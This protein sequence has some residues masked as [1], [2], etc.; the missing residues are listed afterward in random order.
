M[1]KILSAMTI[2]GSLWAANAHAGK[3]FVFHQTLASPFGVFKVVASATVDWDFDGARA[4]YTDP[5]GALISQGIEAFD[6][7]V[8]QADGTLV[9][10]FHK[11]LADLR[12]PHDFVAYELDGT[13]YWQEFLR[14]SVYVDA[15]FNGQIR[16]NNSTFSSNFPLNGS[17]GVF[18]S[19]WTPD[20]MGN[21]PG[22]P[23]CT[24][25]G[26]CQFYG[27]WLPVPEPATMAILATGL[28]GMVSLR[29]RQ[30]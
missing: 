9:G 29:R 20:S 12:P 8:N 16:F 1:R 28:L 14:W 4:N 24:T 3:D 2:L 27:R 30:G 6:F 23:G 10:L 5:A 22:R 11:T 21:I 19:D 7:Q 25:P 17:P 18:S 13:F 26:V 15:D